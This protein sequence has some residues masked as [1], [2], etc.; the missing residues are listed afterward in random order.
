MFSDPNFVYIFFKHPV[1]LHV[2]SHD[3]ASDPIQKNVFLQC[4]YLTVV[5]EKEVR[6]VGYVC[7]CSFV[8]QDFHLIIHKTTELDTDCFA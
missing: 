3:K 4:T 2:H 1:V 7:F 8:S 5:K 6:Y